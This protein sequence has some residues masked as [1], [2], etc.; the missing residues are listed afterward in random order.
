MDQFLIAA[1]YKFI[2]CDEYTKKLPHFRAELKDICKELNILGTLLLAPE[3]INATIAGYSSNIHQVIDFLKSHAHFTD[4]ECKYTHSYDLPFRKLK[5]AIKKEI[6]TL[7]IPNLVPS[8]N[9][10]KFVSPANWDA[11]LL[12]PD[13]IVIDTRNAYETDCGTFKGAIDPKTRHFGEFPKFAQENLDK[14]RHKKIAMFCTGGIRC[15]KA[16]AYL[17]EQGFEDVYQ[18]EGGILKYLQYVEQVKPQ[19]HE[20]IGKCFVFDNRI[21]I[22]ND[23]EQFKSPKENNS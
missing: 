21:T 15:E 6:V 19:E 17:L 13:F 2:H 22:D 14:Q 23:G 10:G 20:W 1:F 4:L 7:R 12:D 5:V 18:L 16:S 9:T 11:L 8:K 3:G